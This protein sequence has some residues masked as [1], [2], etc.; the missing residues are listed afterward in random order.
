MKGH[1]CHLCKKEWLG[2]CFGKHYGKDVSVDDTPVCD[3]YEFGGSA[4]RLKEIE[5]FEK[6]RMVK[7]GCHMNIKEFAKSIG[8]KEYGYPQFAKEEIETAKENGFV[9]VYGASDDLMEFEGAIQDEGG[10]FDGGKVYFNKSEVCQDSEE[11]KNYQNWI[12]AVW[13][14]DEDENG[15]MITWTYETEIPHE[16]F[17]IYEGGEPYCKG[18]VFSIDDVK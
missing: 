3:E 8:G 10:C 7:E 12:N 4:E 9:I 16:T 11:E 18:I 1:N 15:N 6:Q 2:R 5:D 13:D 17:M 14:R